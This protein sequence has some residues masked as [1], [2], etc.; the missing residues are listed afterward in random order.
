MAGPFQ[1]AVLQLGSVL[2]DTERTLAKLADAVADA[3]RGGARWIVFPEALVGGYP[4]GHDFGLTL[5]RR[6]P[7][8]RE[9]F[10]RYHASAIDLPGPECDRLAA[11]ARAAGAWLTGGVIERTPGTLY[12]TAVTFAPDGALVHR[13]RK[14]MPTAL[15]RCLWGAGDASTLAPVPT[16]LG[17]LA[18][19]ICWENYMP[20]LRTAL[21]A[22]GVDLWAALTVDDRDVWQATIRH[23][24]LEGR[25]F[26]LSA[27][28]HLRRDDVPPELA[29]PLAGPAEPDLIRGG[30]AIIGPLG[31]LLAGPAYGSET[32][33]VATLDPAE[34]IRARF[35]FDPVGHYARPDLFTLHV[36]TSPRVSVREQP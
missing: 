26:V 17:S 25:C 13:R 32:T 20:L 16:E 3:A 34:L 1:A 28:Q 4:K 24:A 23:L 30:S 29:L 11:M 15:E 21:H 19:V 35:D 22:R 10:R 2:F 36:D 6:D 7:A 12:C 31:Q 14:L 9:L 5:G 18:P 27:C 8:G 33:L